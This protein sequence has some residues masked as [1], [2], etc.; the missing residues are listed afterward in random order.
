MSASEFIPEGADLATLREASCRCHG[1]DL[2]KHATQT[3]FGQ[4]PD[5]ASVVLVGEQPG[6]R[7]DVAGSPFVGP[8]GHLLDRALAEA[9]I[10][11][12]AVYLTN[13]VKHFKFTE[14]GKRRIHQQPG[15]TEITACRPWLEAEL[16]RIEPDLVVCLGAIAAQSVID[17]KFR[18]SKQRGQVVRLG[19]SR[20]VA[21]VH[22]SA[23]LRS[24]D[25]DTAYA[26][27][28]ADLRIARAA[29]G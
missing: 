7:E 26:E 14:R 9:G 21:T 18:V 6:D 11:R 13:A 23:V 15:R 3:V 1:C 5:S 16:G 25:R 12:D 20:A 28:L 8:A 2:Y 24:P 4:G 10:D 22:P 29:M 17:P 27:F 19:A